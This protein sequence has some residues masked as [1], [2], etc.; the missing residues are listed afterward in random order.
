MLI[1]L[2]VLPLVQ[3]SWTAAAP[4]WAHESNPISFHVGHHAHV[5]EG[6]SLEVKHT[7]SKQGNVDP[8]DPCGLGHS[9]GHYRDGVTGQLAYPAASQFELPACHLFLTVASPRLEGKNVR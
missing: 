3:F 4:Y 9:G 6:A 2:I 8:Q 7:P 1:V 5:Y